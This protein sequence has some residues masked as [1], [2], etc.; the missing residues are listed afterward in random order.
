[1]PYMTRSSDPRVDAALRRLGI[2]LRH[3]RQISGMSQ[4]RVET[5]TG[6]DQTTISRLENGLATRL[7]LERLGL[8]LVAIDVELR[9]R[10]ASDT[11]KMPDGASLDGRSDG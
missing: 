3:G 1:M 8:I 4:R 6:V 7:P 2:Q 11:Q 9:A 10:R 5:R